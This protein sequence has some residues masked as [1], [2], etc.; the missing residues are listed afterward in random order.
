MQN[1]KITGKFA[2]NW[3]HFRYDRRWYRGRACCPMPDR[4][5]QNPQ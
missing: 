1:L 2:A 3:L 4:L 5:V